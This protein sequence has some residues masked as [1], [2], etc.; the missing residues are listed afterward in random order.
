MSILNFLKKIKLPSFRF[1][2]EFIVDPVDQVSPEDELWNQIAVAIHREKR[3]QRKLNS[4]LDDKEFPPSPLRWGDGDL[5]DIDAS[6]VAM[7]YYYF[8]DE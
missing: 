7:D 2:N 5:V 1:E 3:I 4:N 6:I 8:D